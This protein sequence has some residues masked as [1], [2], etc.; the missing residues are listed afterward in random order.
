MS[1]EHERAG[2]KGNFNIYDFEGFL[3][4]S[5]FSVP[6]PPRPATR[7]RE[8]MGAVNTRERIM[9][10]GSFKVKAHRVVIHH[11]YFINGLP[12]AVISG[13]FEI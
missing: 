9:A 11:L 1:G 8:T 3:R 4:V 13:Y 6:H 5:G 2:A 12:L 10:E 7:L